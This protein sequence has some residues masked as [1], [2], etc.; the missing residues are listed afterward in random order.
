MSFKP[1]EQSQLQIPMQ[2]EFMIEKEHIARVV[3]D[4]VEEIFVLPNGFRVE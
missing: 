1:Y 4:V 3:N 2:W